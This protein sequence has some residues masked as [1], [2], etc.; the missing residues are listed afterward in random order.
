MQQI[1]TAALASL[2]RRLEG[3]EHLVVTSHA[4]PDGDAVGSTVAL[5][6]Y[7]VSSLHK[8]AH[9]V[10][11]DEPGD[12][13][14][15]IIP[16]SLRGRVLTGPDAG[17]NV[18]S[19]CD[20]ILCLDC[21][22]FPRTESL[23]PLLE[24]APARER[25]LIDHHVGPESDSFGLVFSETEI[26]S[27]CE[28]LYWILTGITGSA[29]ALP[30]DC[31]AALMTGMTT[32]T[33]N[34]AN[35]VFPSTLEMASGL[36]K[37]GV[38]RDTILGN[39]YNQGRENRLRLM[40]HALS[41]LLR[42]SDRGAATIILRSEDKERFDIREGETE[43]FVNLPLTVARVRISL[44]LKEEDG[45]FRVSIRARKGL[46]ARALATGYFHGGG[47]ELAAGGKVLIPGDISSPDQIDAYVANILEQFLS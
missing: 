29:E 33:N 36:L 24:A 4:H 11:P 15:F 23:Q 9:V 40:G 39:L 37:A 22:G 47:H 2:A 6:S 5:L 31:A 30:A 12:N 21:N 7:L 13:L 42:I 16:D 35:S 1:E 32:D 38:D 17:K 34:F 8:D 43:G 18:I 46:S 27:T 3:A 28:L 45:L 26:S 44:L 19:R 20:T 25:I 14:R 41:D 10:L